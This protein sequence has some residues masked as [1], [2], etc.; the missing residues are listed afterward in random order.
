MLADYQSF[1]RRYTVMEEPV[2]KFNVTLHLVITAEDADA[3][4]EIV[5]DILDDID[6]ADGVEDAAADDPVEEVG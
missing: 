3:A 4:G 2:K 6:A 1:I 5:D